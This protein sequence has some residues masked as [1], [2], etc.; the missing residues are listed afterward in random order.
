MLK[1]KLRSYICVSSLFCSLR[2]VAGKNLPLVS[3][4]DGLYRPLATFSSCLRCHYVPLHAQ[5]NVSVAHSKTQD[6]E[7]KNIL[8]ISIQSEA[9]TK[10]VL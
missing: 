8:F 7:T 2:K 4:S 3:C 5:L 6:L 1:F 10:G 9:A